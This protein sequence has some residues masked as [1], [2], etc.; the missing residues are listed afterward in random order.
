MESNVAAKLTN[1]RRGNND[2]GDYDQSD[3]PKEYNHNPNF[4]FRVIVNLVF[5]I[6]RRRFLCGKRINIR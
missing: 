1:R 2:N 5:G 6:D 4:A 3:N